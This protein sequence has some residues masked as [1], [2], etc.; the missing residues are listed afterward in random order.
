M[1]K[2]GKRSAERWEGIHPDAILI[3]SETLKVT[4]ID[5]GAPTDAGVRTA[6]RQKEIFD[7]PGMVTK[8]DG[9][10]KHSKHQ[11]KA[12]DKYGM[13]FDFYALVNNRASWEISHLSL[14][15]GALHATS[16]RLLQKGLI[17]HE[18]VWGGTFGSDRFHGWD[19]GHCE[20]KKVV[21]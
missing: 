5:F 21:N 4:L 9:Y 12:G 1:F 14:V 6:K 11:I 10:Y 20:L 18:L 16:K 17:T 7:A 8:C 15:Y 2:L 3:I 13:A 19:G